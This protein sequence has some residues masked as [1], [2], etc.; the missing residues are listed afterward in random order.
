MELKKMLVGLEGLKVK[1]NLEIEINGLES[2]SK[3]IKQGYLFV[4][5]KGFSTDGHKYVQSAIQNGAVAIMIEEGCNLKTL[6]IPENITIIMAKDTR[7]GLAIT[8]SN[9]Y[10][11]PSKKL[12]LIGVT[13]TKGKQQQHLW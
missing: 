8:S 11:N 6:E 5:I 4:A 10:G 3:N 2:N 9:F 7:E 1:G 13:G 12:K